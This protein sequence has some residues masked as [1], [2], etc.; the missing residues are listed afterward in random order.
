MRRYLLEN[1]GSGRGSKY[2]QV[3]HAIIADIQRGRLQPGDRLPSTRDLA[4]TLGVH[5]KTII[6]AYDELGRQG[7]VTA[8]AARFT[9]VSQELPRAA[10][11]RAAHRAEERQRAGFELP[12][13]LVPDAPTRRRGD[14][15]LLLGGVPELRFTKELS[16][17]RAYGRSLRGPAG[18]RLL[19]Y[20]DPQ[21]DP[22]LRDALAEVL[23]RTRAL[24]CSRA[25]IAVVRGSQEAL[26]LLARTLVRA[27]DRVA[28]EALG[29]PQAWG[30]FRA[31]GADLVPIPVD[32]QGLNV[33]KLAAAIRRQ[34]V[35]ALYL[36]PHHQLPT[37][38]TLSQERR[39]E[40]LALAARERFF[41][42]EDDYDHE[43]Q[44]DS[45]PVLPLA[46]RDIE[47]LV[48]Y[49]GT[50]SKT[51]APGLRIG[52]VVG[53]RDVIDRITS[54]RIY[55][56]QQGDHVVERTIADLI[57]EGELERHVR[58]ACR[59]Y[60]SRRD[61]LAA[62]LRCQLPQLSFSVPGG[63][64]AIWAKVAG[65]GVDVDAWARRGAAAGVAFQVASH[66]AVDRKPRPFLRLGFAACNEAE[67]KEATRRM[68]ATFDPSAG[69]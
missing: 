16:I 9:K 50:L 47:G 60:R 54:Y 42:V 35:R 31:V 5:R 23:G 6:A 32:A 14:A 21:G 63:G 18:R 58:R 36:T 46:S 40:L 11:G 64:M 12:P 39:A 24:R 4:Q 61:A 30:A 51:L 33:D 69:D 44:Y 25:S 20:C 53:P 34:S 55:V 48:I 3:A 1:P 8:E 59:V 27:G 2:L 29:Y 68:A 17:A 62:A 43:F 49:V 19:D 37:T 45:N 7:W 26:Y 41:I 52:F 10:P 28:V 56:D 65:A 38:V 13:R 66:F 22:R 15:L 67:L 57:E